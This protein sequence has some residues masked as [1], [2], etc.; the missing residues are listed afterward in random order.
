LDS[1]QLVTC[2]LDSATAG[3]NSSSVY[4]LKVTIDIGYYQKTNEIRTI[5][6]CSVSY[7]LYVAS[8]ANF[9]YQLEM[10]FAPLNHTHILLNFGFDW[11]IYVFVFMIIGLLSNIQFLIFW[12]YHLIITTKAKRTFNIKIYLKLIK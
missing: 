1:S 2:K 10:S 5:L 9:S 4:P 6:T 7:S 3:T 12:I 8:T 11:Y